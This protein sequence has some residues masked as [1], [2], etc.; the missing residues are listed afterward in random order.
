M[1]GFLRTLFLLLTACCLM[2]AA[3]VEPLPLADVPVPDAL[4]GWTQWAVHGHE[5]ERCPQV[6]AGGRST[7]CAWI[8]ELS[9]DLGPKGG[10]FTMRVD[11]FAPVD[12]QLP[13]A[14]PVWPENVRADKAAVPVARSGR[15]SQAP[16]VHLEAGTHVL[17]GTFQWEEVPANMSF[18]SSAGVI[19]L[20]WD[21]KKV[22]SPRFEN[23]GTLILS[24]L[25][26]SSASA[27]DADDGSGSENGEGD[28]GED[29]AKPNE[30]IADSL[31]MTVY[32]KIV[33]DIPISLTTHIDLKFSGKRREDVIGPVLPE[34]FVPVS[35]DAPIPARIDEKGMLRVMARPGDYAVNIEARLEGNPS[36]FKMPSGEGDR[37][38]S[39]EIWAFEAAPEL[40]QVRVYGADTVDPGQTE[41]PSAWRSLSAYRMA[42]DTKLEIVETHRGKRSAEEGADEL[43]LSREMWL[44]FDGGGFSVVDNVTGNLSRSRRL[45]AR[46][47]MKLGSIAVSGEPMLITKSDEGIGVELKQGSV[48]MTAAGR[49]LREGDGTPLSWNQLFKSASVELNLPPGWRLLGVGGSGVSGSGT[50]IDGWTLLSVFLLLLCAV[51]AGKLLGIGAGILA[52][53][54]MLLTIPEE[55]SLVWFVLILLAAEGLLR[56]FEK[57]RARGFFGVVRWAARI[58]LVLAGLFFC[59]EQLGE[60]VHPILE[61]SYTVMGSGYSGYSR[62]ESNSFWDSM[63]LGGS[64]LSKGDDEYVEMAQMAPTGAA[65]SKAAGVGGLGGYGVRRRMAEEDGAAVFEDMEAPRAMPAME[66]AQAL[67]RKPAGARTN[68]MPA[69][70]A[71]KKARPAGST[72]RKAVRT[73]MDAATQTGEGIPSWYWKSHSVSFDGPADD[74]ASMSLWLVPPGLHRVA[75][76]LRVLLMVAL[77]LILFGI[78]RKISGI[79]GTQPAGASKAGASAAAVL[80]LTGLVSSLTLL[81]PTDAAAAPGAS[82][83]AGSDLPS[84]QM[85]DDLRGRLLKRPACTP[86]CG[87]LTQ[88]KL[89][90][91]AADSRMRAEAVIHAS[92]PTALPLPGIDGARFPASVRTDGGDAVLLRD[93][94]GVLWAYVGK[95]IHTIILEG[96]VPQRGSFTVSMPESPKKTVVSSAEGFTISGLQPN[97]QIQGGGL[98]VAPVSS[99]SPRGAAPVPADLSGTND[100]GEGEPGEGEKDDDDLDEELEEDDAWKNSFQPLFQTVRTFRF[101]LTW[102]V[103]TTVN[104]LSPDDTSVIIDVPLLPGEQVLTDGVQVVDRNVRVSMPPGE[105]EFTWKS[106]LETSE[107]ISLTAIQGKPIF[108]RWEFDVGRRWHVEYGN[109]VPLVSDENG[110]LPGELSGEMALFRPLPGETLE[111]AVTQPQSAE[112]RQMTLQ[113]SSLKVTPGS[114]QLEATLNLEIIAS[115]GRQHPIRLPVGAKLSK[116]SVNGR[117]SQARLSDEG[118]LTVPVTPGRTKI[119]AVWTQPMELGLLFNAPAVDAGIEGVNASSQISMGSDRWILFV[120]GAPAGPV[121]RFW[122]LLLGMLLFAFLLGRFGQSKPG[123]GSWALLL[124]GLAVIKASIP[125]MIATS[126]W[127]LFMAWRGR[128]PV[129]TRWKFNLRQIVAV[130]WTVVFVCMLLAVVGRGLM[131]APDMRIE[132]MGSSGSEL[133]WFTDRTS[134]GILPAPWVLTIPMFVYKGAM[135]LWALWL[136]FALVGWFRWG[137]HAFGEGGM[138]KAAPPKPAKVVETKVAK[139]QQPPAKPNAAPSEASGSSSGTAKADDADKSKPASDDASA[140]GKSE[141]KGKSKKS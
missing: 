115:V 122:S 24:F 47:P 92:A 50:W 42:K 139:G 78:R 116:V 52:F 119:T 111:V 48:K 106:S 123:F 87:S 19:S 69:K 56:L 81:S 112:G 118:V 18:D 36:S 131:G 34:G 41:M 17:D 138:W 62:R 65:S 96:P 58:A 114:R 1:S 90:L 59:T 3:P 107:R 103:E 134:T 126:G 77:T 54:T 141:A 83:K 4:K 21:G 140:A 10:R 16:A 46:D 67:E 84:A 127:L 133:N 7:V 86:N 71:K 2:A 12:V 88:L 15:Y 27:A 99:V 132:G 44:D 45:T 101:G 11:A 128:T 8:S 30:E 13:W 113:S 79:A 80:L 29:G 43:F 51:A 97:G 53:A 31:E 105:D 125:A 22:A 57:T 73:T 121:V 124:G 35:M 108:E 9:F 38:V 55:E 70:A 20:T 14:R 72:I 117:D 137:F 37:W 61:R 109:G 135:L 76:I 49:I 28:D 33:D 68:A 95:G 6:A 26:G 130:I 94:R 93:S 110:R 75:S 63:N 64:M 40:R 129:L 82:D 98:I 91:S 85:L 102:E 5:T 39:E 74:K 136:A 25:G 120:G 23:Q 89:S 66:P 32:R 100:E 104:R 60:G